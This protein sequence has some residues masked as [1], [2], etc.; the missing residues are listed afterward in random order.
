MNRVSLAPNFTLKKAGSSFRAAAERTRDEHDENQH[1][2]GPAAVE[3]GKI[4]CEDRA[5]DD[6]TLR[7][8]VPKPH[9]KGQ[10]HA[11]R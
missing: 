8:D 11:E 9:F 1:G 2:M 4:G 7:P 6:L 10:R 3:Q 5:H